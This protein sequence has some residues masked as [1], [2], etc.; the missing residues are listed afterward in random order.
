MGKKGEMGKRESEDL[1][2]RILLTSFEF[3]YFE[4][5]VSNFQFL[6]SGFESRILNRTAEHGR[7]AGSLSRRSSTP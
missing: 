6:V 5:P 3:R 7:V 4:F 1:G 2:F